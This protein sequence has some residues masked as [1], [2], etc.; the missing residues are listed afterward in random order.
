MRLVFVADK[1]DAT[2][3]LEAFEL[4]LAYISGEDFSQPILGA[5]NLSGRSAG[6]LRQGCR[7]GR[8]CQTP[9]HCSG[10]SSSNRSIGS[11][12]GQS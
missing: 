12:Q 2:S 11:Q 6:G 5:N 3:G 8:G 1:A 9:R 10:S 7:R 4:P